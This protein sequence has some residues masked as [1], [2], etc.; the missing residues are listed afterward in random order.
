MLACPLVDSLFACL[1]SQST[2]AG[3]TFRALKLAAG[4]Q[5]NREARRGVNVPPAL[6]RQRC[7]RHHCGAGCVTFG[8]PRRPRE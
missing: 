3:E 2:Y 4:L 6:R 1:A 7:W 5:W 8:A